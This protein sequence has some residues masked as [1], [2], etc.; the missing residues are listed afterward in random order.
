M[1]GKA[2]DFSIATDL[3]FVQVVRDGVVEP[4]VPL[5]PTKN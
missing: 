3:Y 5:T 2:A 1:T 4:L